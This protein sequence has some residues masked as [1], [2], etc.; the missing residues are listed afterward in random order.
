MDMRLRP[1]TVSKAMDQFKERVSNQMPR[2]EVAGVQHRPKDSYRAIRRDVA[3]RKRR[4][5]PRPRIE[6]VTFVRPPGKPPYDH[7]SDCRTEAGI[8]VDSLVSSLLRRN[9]R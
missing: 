5:L 8:Q 9:R 4:Q 1:S 6:A 7:R 3:K 2:R